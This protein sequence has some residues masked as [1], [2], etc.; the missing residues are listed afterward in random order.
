MN[1]IKKAVV[2]LISVNKFDAIKWLK[3]NETFW[4]KLRIRI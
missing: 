2:E 3:I 4:L 1:L